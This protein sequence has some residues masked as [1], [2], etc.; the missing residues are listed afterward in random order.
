VDDESAVRNLAK[1]TLKRVG[2]TSLSAGDGQ[3][4]LTLFRESR[5]EIG[6][7]LLDLT[8]P[9]MD[10]QEVLREIRALSP[11]LP[12]ILSSGFSQDQALPALQG[13][14]RT[15]FLQK[16]Y[17]PPDLQELMTSLLEPPPEPGR[18]GTK[19]RSIA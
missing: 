19:G 17:A 16:P 1:Q 13:D 12:V 8:M 18:E 5:A 11:E 4:G 10:G 2:F 7:V 14:P 3:E 9:G 15:H 6:A